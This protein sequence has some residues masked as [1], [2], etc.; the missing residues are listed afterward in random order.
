[1]TPAVWLLPPQTEMNPD[2]A[3]LSN[4]SHS[5]RRFRLSTDAVRAQYNLH[6][7]FY[8]VSHACMK[9]MFSAVYSVVVVG[10]IGHETAWD[11]G[12]YSCEHLHLGASIHR[13]PSQ[14]HNQ[15]F[16][17]YGLYQHN[18]YSH[19]FNYFCFKCK[20]LMKFILE[21]TNYVKEQCLPQYQ[22]SIL[23]VLFK[24]LNDHFNNLPLTPL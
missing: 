1:M 20:K 11:E 23:L 3:N 14:K 4:N 16:G 17:F 21:Q 5:H 9:L 18:K 13:L 22:T 24:L 10:V 6:V 19:F 8:S 2:G 12:C 7:K 15:S